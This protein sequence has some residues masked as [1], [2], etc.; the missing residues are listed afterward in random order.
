MWWGW[1][2][3]RWMFFGS[4]R[5]WRWERK[6]G[7]RGGG[8]F[9]S[10]EEVGGGVG[11][12]GEGFIG[13]GV[14][15]GGGGLGVEPGLTGERFGLELRELDWETLICDGEPNGEEGRGEEPL[16]M[17]PPTRSPEGSSKSEAFSESSELA[18][19]EFAACHCSRISGF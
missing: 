17:R 7:R 16:S 5:V 18:C 1:K 10:Q 3:F 15:G 12:G 11:G 14:G 4:K 2:I 13:G 9:E 8:G 19:G 6:E